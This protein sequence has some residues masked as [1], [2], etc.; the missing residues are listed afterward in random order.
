[1]QIAAYM[2]FS[3]IYLLGV[4]CS[5]GVVRKNFVENYISSGFPNPFVNTKNGELLS[6]RCAEK[7]SRTHG[8]RI[9][10]ATR[11]GEL[12]IFEKRDFDSMFNDL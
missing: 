10:N 12:E 8:F 5:Y 9:Y 11:G 1:M 7:Y 2:G 6:Y 3:V 4:D